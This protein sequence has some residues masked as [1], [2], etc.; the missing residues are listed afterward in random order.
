MCC[1][2]VCCVG[3]F[4]LHGPGE[5]FTPP[6]WWTFSPT[7]ADLTVFSDG[8]SDDIQ[9]VAGRFVSPLL[10]PTPFGQDDV[11][12][13]ERANRLQERFLREPHPGVELP[14]ILGPDPLQHLGKGDVV[15]RFLEAEGSSGD[16]QQHL[17]FPS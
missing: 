11:L 9:S 15:T 3:E 13:F 2:T 5:L 6:P 4:L 10:A 8:V 16:I 14:T 7:G 1:L 17:Q 12:L